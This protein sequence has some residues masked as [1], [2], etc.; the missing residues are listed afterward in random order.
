M[1]HEPKAKHCGAAGAVRPELVEAA[2]CPKRDQLALVADDD[3]LVARAVARGLSRLGYRVCT[4]RSRAAAF[5]MSG[6]YAVGVFDLDLGDGSGVEL[7]EDLLG[8]GRVGRV[9]FY[10][11]SR[12]SQVL[13]RARLIGP[14]VPKPAG[15]DA[16]LCAVQEPERCVVAGPP[17]A[18]D[19]S[20]VGLLT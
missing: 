12:Y 20:L 4:A 15:V 9:L 1:N 14:V 2:Q 16:L 6:S 5:A 3:P 7:A 19:G 8:Q 11:G 18:R 13:D 17:G 10:T